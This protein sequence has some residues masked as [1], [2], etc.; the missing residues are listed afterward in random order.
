MRRL[1]FFGRF[2]LE[3]AVVHKSATCIVMFGSD[4][5]EQ[6]EEHSEK[7]DGNDTDAGSNAGDDEFDFG[8]DA[9][10]KEEEQEDEEGEK[11]KEKEDS[12]EENDKDEES[13][14]NAEDLGGDM[15]EI[16][17][18][19]TV[20]G[21][22][23]EDS[24]FFGL[25]ASDQE[26]EEEEE[27]GEEEEEEEEEE[28]KKPACEAPLVALKFMRYKEQFERELASREENGLEGAYVI[29]TACSFD[30]D[31]DGDF[32]RECAK[33]GLAGY[34]YCVVMPRADRNLLDAIL[35]EHFAG[36][37]W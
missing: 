19:E 17:A 15:D 11:K 3:P 13:G 20:D 7:D 14:S 10:D 21:N 27:E 26:E 23:Q 35:H 30:G 4:H 1:Y 24:D 9:S 22:V 33:K 8:L 29:D 31:E 16:I 12:E 34:H 5:A 32:V 37:D 28:A 2:N 18:A 25:N 36:Y 6:E